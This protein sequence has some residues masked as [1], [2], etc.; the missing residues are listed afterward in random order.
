MRNPHIKKTHVQNKQNEAVQ[1]GESWAHNFPIQLLYS[2]NAGQMDS[3]PG[4]HIWTP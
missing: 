3:H 2:T 4:L 1:N